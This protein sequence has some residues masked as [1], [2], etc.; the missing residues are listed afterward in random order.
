MLVRKFSFPH[1]VW[2]DRCALGAVVTVCVKPFFTHGHPLEQARGRVVSV[3]ILMRVVSSPGLRVR[4][5]DQEPSRF[6]FTD[7]F[8]GLRQATHVDLRFR[9]LGLPQA[10]VVRRVFT[11]VGQIPRATYIFHHAGRY[12][13]PNRGR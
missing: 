5:E 3:H 2:L 12:R 10:R 9:I 4:R 7:T 8:T 1:D 6:A 13:V 11:A